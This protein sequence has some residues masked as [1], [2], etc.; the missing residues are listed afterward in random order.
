VTSRALSFGAAA[1]SYERFRLGYPE[2]VGDLVVGYAHPPLRRALEVGAGTGKATRLFTGRGVAVTA[3]EPDPAMLAVL[4][5]ETDGLAVRP[6]Q[7]RFEDF[8]ADEPYDLLYAAASWHWTDPETRW[9]HA[10]ELVRPGGT[11]AFFA[12]DGNVRALLADPDIREAFDAARRGI[13]DDD[14]PLTSGQSAS[15]LWWP[16]TEI[17]ERSEF[18]DLEEREILRT[19]R[20]SRE[21]FLGLLTTNSLYL[22]LAPTDQTELSRRVGAALPPTVAVQADVRIHLA[23]RR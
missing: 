7:S 1:E 16:G 21:D 4:V 11:L 17:A 9:P 20:R 23:R 18:A 8:Q 22:Q 6:V 12:S 5:R 2:A 15:G 14:T 10:A 13:L 3:C 19:V